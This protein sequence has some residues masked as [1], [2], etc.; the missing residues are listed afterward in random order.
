M[1][2]RMD[3]DREFIKTDSGIENDA[4]S[5]AAQIGL[6]KAIKDYDS[7]GLSVFTTVS[8]GGII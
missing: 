2:R 4:E 1:N 6:L 8:V 7:N 5:L 3:Q